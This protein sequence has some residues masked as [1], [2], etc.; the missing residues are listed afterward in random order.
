MNVRTAISLDAAHIHLT[1]VI[2][3]SAI[4]G[5]EILVLQELTE[6]L[7]S[8]RDALGLTFGE[9]AHAPEALV[10]DLRR[11]LAVV[12][13]FAEQDDSDR[14][15]LASFLDQL[16]FTRQIPLE[17]S[18]LERWSLAELWTLASTSTGGAAGV[19][20]A[21][22]AGGRGLVLVVCAFF[23]TLL[24]RPLRAISEGLAEG[25]QPP[26]REATER[27]A[28]QWLLGERPDAASRLARRGSESQPPPAGTTAELPE[29][30]YEAWFVLRRLKEHMGHLV[31]YLER[32]AADAHGEPASATAER[33]VQRLPEFTP[34]SGGSPSRVDPTGTQLED[35]AV[36]SDAL[37]NLS[38]LL[39]RLE[40][41]L[42]DA[43]SDVVEAARDTI[44]T[45]EIILRRWGKRRAGA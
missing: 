35:E 18:P 41:E 9:E 29:V 16:V 32:L 36:I 40:A 22:V 26:V 37:L 13:E 38:R 14:A 5:A 25:L 7:D 21:Y 10:D 45:M 6:G 39:D 33:L 44:E 19:A 28:R 23:G 11:F 34:P 4:A 2:S 43:P 12:W 1:A 15:R 31:P 27:Y 17:Q 24:V 8:V 3:P 20:I 30:L 42:E